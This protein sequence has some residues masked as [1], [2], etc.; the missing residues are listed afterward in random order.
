MND[1]ARALAANRA[2]VAAALAPAEAE[3]AECRQRCA[4][5]EDSIRRARLIVDGPGEPESVRQMTLHEAMITVLQER[6]TPLSAPELAD[7]IERRGLYHRRD[8]RPAGGGQ[9]HN[10]VNQYP[11]LFVRD[12]GL[13]ALR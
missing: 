2:A 11:N 13:I 1:L 12:S 8:G 3:L 6:G 5:L 10:R 7:E 9:V 4:E